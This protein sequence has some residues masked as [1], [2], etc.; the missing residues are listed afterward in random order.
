MLRLLLFVR[1]WH[2]CLRVTWVT[3][4]KSCFCLVF[5]NSLQTACVCE[6]LC[7]EPWLKDPGTLHPARPEATGSRGRCHVGSPHRDP[8]QRPLGL[9]VQVVASS[10][11]HVEK[12]RAVAPTQSPLWASLCGVTTPCALLPGNSHRGCGH[13]SSP[14]LRPLGS[15]SE[16]GAVCGPT[17]TTKMTLTSSASSCGGFSLINSGSPL[18]PLPPCGC[19]VNGSL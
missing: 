3:F 4:L 10:V 7:F 17:S 6:G 8:E 13:I 15:Q 12:L 1:S 19:S 2:R 9:R 5:F 16:P 11:P 14:S 18:P